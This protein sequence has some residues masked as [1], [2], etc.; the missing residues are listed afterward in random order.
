MKKACIII[1]AFGCVFISVTLSLIDLKNER[2]LATVLSI[3]LCLSFWIFL[4]FMKQQYYK[5]KKIKFSYPNFFRLGNSLLLTYF[6]YESSIPTDKEGYIVYLIFISLFVFTFYI[7]SFLR[8]E[9]N[10]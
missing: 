2:L 3:I 1:S 7:T 6:I 4:Y 5:D 9:K 8:V 10:S